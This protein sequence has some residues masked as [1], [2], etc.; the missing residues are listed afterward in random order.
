MIEN[1]Q[2]KAG[3]GKLTRYSRREDTVP[4]DHAGA[5]ENHDEEGGVQVLVLLEPHLDAG[6]VHGFRVALQLVGG[7]LLVRNLPVGQEAHIGVPAN[8]RVEGKRPSCGTRNTC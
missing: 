3:G 8:Q 1:S 6:F 5:N 4:N 7:E 2:R